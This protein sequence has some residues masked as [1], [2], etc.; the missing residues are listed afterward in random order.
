VLTCH[1]IQEQGKRI[2]Y[3]ETMIGIGDCYLTG[4][5]ST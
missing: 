5:L 4:N 2:C 3:L 1:V